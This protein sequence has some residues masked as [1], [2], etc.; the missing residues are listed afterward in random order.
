MNFKA[1]NLRDY[2]ER[3]EGMEEASVM[4][5]GLNEKRII[6]GINILIKDNVKLKVVK[7]Y[8]VTNFSS[9]IPRLII[10]YLNSVEKKWR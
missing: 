9:K 6:S 1:L 2:T 5:V 10:S 4:M 7:D 3:L 8:N